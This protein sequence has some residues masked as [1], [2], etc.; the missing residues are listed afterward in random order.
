[1]DDIERAR[2]NALQLASFRGTLGFGYLVLG[3]LF[4]AALVSYSR[5]GTLGAVEFALAAMA[6]AYVSQLLATFALERLAIIVQT[7]SALAAIAAFLSL[8]G[9]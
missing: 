7:L 6:A 4:L 8:R 5:F 1:M 2:V 9:I 3:A